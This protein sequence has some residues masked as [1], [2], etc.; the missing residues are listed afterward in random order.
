MGYLNKHETNVLLAFAEIFSELGKLKAKKNAWSGESYNLEHAKIVDI[1]TEKMVLEVT[2][3][4]RSKPSK[5]ETV[6]I[7][8]GE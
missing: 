7:D 8:L 4:E 5:V 1:D 2:V 6:S 3:Q